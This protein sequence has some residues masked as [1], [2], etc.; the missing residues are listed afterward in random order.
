MKLIAWVITKSNMQ[1]SG[2]VCKGTL[3][4]LT[5]VPVEIMCTYDTGAQEI[6]LVP[7]HSLILASS[8][9]FISQPT[10]N[11]MR[12]QGKVPYS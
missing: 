8:L 1:R 11:L 12:Q 6:D 3:D 10:C 2:Y 7:I 4:P 9:Q 5:C